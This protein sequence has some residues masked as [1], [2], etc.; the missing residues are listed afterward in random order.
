MMRRKKARTK[1]Q[2]LMRLKRSDTDRVLF[3]AASLLFLT[4]MF[5]FAY[6]GALSQ[7]SEILSILISVAYLSYA[8]LY[9]ICNAYGLR[10]GAGLRA[11]FC[12]VLGLFIVSAGYIIVSLKAS[13]A[14]LLGYESY[15]VLQTAP[16]FLA[17][18][19]MVFLA[20]SIESHGRRSREI[21]VLSI[22]IYAG[23]IAFFLVA[24]FLLAALSTAAPVHEVVHLN[25]EE[26]LTMSSAAALA[27]G[28]NPYTMD[29]SGA[30]LSNVSRAN[31]TT[32]AVASPTL[33][34]ANG[35]AATLQYPSLS[36]LVWLPV[37]L[38]EN[39]GLL[40]LSY[41]GMYILIALF[42][43]ILVLAVARV[44]PPEQLKRPQIIL[45]LFLLIASSIFASPV[46]SL[47][48]ALVIIALCR[49]GSRYLWLV[50]GLLASLQQAMWVLVA[51]FL[52][53]TFRN[54]G[55]AH[56][57]RS[58]IGTVAIFL[59]ANGFFMAA[60]PGAFANNILSTSNGSLLPSPYPVF[61][62]SL[63][64]SYPIPLN[65][66]FVFVA[67]VV[68]VLALM[69]YLNVKRLIPLLGL[70]PLMFLF[71]LTPTYY[72]FFVSALVISLYID[73][74]DKVKSIGRAS[75]GIRRAAL[76]AI[77]GASALFACVQ[78]TSAH[79]YYAK[80][81][82]TS[83]NA[84]ITPEGFYNITLLSAGAQH[85]DVYIA[86]YLT[87][88]NN[89]GVYFYGGLLEDIVK[90][91]AQIGPDEVRLNGSLTDVSLALPVNS[92][93]PYES[94]PYIVRC[95]VYNNGIYYTCQ[96]ATS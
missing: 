52:V 74:G 3:A 72:V 15:L 79:T 9:L 91:P 40:H 93:S 87:Y 48:L 51:L 63:V 30:L 35:V 85:A 21:R 47:M 95:V 90:A 4:A 81:A 50:L 22:A 56:G 78:V 86:E 44:I 80:Q 75:A 76:V 6:Y 46:D 11:A 82:I 33:T 25:D 39:A 73:A 68:I 57:V 62:Y 61:G 59:I 45:V 20:R 38:L 96:A 83:S 66:G 5:C 64:Q 89:V 29:F 53:Y 31:A 67:A 65:D 7:V 42:M 36:F 28:S 2:L 12:L 24:S 84:T 58:L 41:N 10:P 43:L 69:A 70:I 26:F 14:F 92:T 60:S 17:L 88:R 23:A 49:T 1:R 54:Y 94:S 8:A 19:L 34:T 18:I 27:H 77:V 37:A 55:K 13:V 16:L 32:T 71:H